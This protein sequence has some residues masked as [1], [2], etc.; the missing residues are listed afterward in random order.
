MQDLIDAARA[1]R[2]NAYC[3]Y[4]NYPVG[5]AV[6]TEDGTI[7][8]GCNVENVSYGLSICAERN[9]IFAMVAGGR[10]KL[11][12][13]VVVTRDGGFPCGACL[14]VISEFAAPHAKIHLVDDSGSATTYALPGLLPHPFRI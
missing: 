7:F 13:L 12:E 10:K 11:T 1:A 14:Q 3:P 8:A 5:A 2:A 9:A 4:S 6:R